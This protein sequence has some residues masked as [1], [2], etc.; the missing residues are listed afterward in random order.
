MSGMLLKLFAV[1]LLL[2]QAP[3]QDGPRDCG[4]PASSRKVDEYGQLSAAEELS[5][6][7]KLRPALE[8][9]HEDAKA[10]I[11]VY[12]GREGRAGE[13]L[14]RADRAKK[15]LADKSYF[16]SGRLNT[17]DCGRRETASI[18]LWITPVGASPPPC[19]PTLGPAAAPAK[20]APAGRRSARRRG[21]RP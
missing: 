1:A 21:G 17:L 9:E 20:D 12:A 15:A 16:Y 13:A 6:L 8:A 4:L 3:R 5:R 7:E 18:E 14:V 10:F 2:A 11:V 19:A